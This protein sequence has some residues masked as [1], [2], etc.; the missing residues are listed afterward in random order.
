VVDIDGII[1]GQLAMLEQ[2]RPAL[3]KEATVNAFKSVKTFSPTRE[4]WI[5]ELEVFRNL[6]MVNQRVYA[7]GYVSAGPF[8][9]PFSNLLIRQHENRDAPVKVVK[10]YYQDVPEHIRKIEGEIEESTLLSKAHHKVILWF[11]EQ[12]GELSLNRY[13]I[14]GYQKTAWRDTVHFE[15]LGNI[16]W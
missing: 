14:T 10:L 9:D 5:S 4:D 16:Q 15:V 2:R 11:E 3:A 7:D 13:K 8:D 1:D 12:S 6:G